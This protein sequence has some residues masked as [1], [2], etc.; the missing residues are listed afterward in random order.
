VERSLGQRE[1]EGEMIVDF[2]D[3]SEIV[4]VHSTEGNTI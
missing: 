2:E 1:A 3:K 4:T